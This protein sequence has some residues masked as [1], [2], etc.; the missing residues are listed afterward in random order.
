MPGRHIFIGDI[1]GCIDELSELLSRI[2]VS[3]GDT[4]IALGDLTRKGPAPDRCVQL[5]AERGYLSVLGNNDAK[6]LARARSWR[7]RVFSL[8]SDRKILRRRDLLE[9]IRRWPLHLDFSAMGI[10]AVHGG[11]LPNGEHFSA[12]L[13]PREAALELRHIRRDAQ[14]WRMVPRGE[15]KP[16]DPFWSEVWNGDRLI[17][18]GHTPREKPKV[19]RRAIGLDTGCVYGG[20]L[21]AA[22][23]DEAGNWEL[24]DVRARRRYSR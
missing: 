12:E 3:S 23:F 15:E 20:K 10:A 1:H 8:P 5:W 24:V 22:V 21:T 11:V 17:V 9:T 18:Y 7:R 2:G 19:D 13:V 16:G 4:V 14:R 6:M